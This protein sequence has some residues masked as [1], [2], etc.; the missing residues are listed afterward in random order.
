MQ[1]K[2]DFLKE[3]MSDPALVSSPM[4]LD[5]FNKTY[6]L[7]CANRGCSRAGSNNMGFDRRVQNWQNDLFNNVP[8]A[9]DNDPNFVHI[10][11]K[12]F[13]PAGQRIVVPG[14]PK[15]VNVEPTI[16]PTKFVRSE[17][18]P[19]APIVQ[20]V[21]PEVSKEPEKPLA[22]REEAKKPQNQENTNFEQGTVLPGGEPQIPKE[23]IMQ[24]GSSFTFGDE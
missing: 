5:E 13:A 15:F 10:R 3:C 4:Q 23:T 1:N 7:V 20:E 24:P 11:M 6:C 8:R 2:P 22:V 17:P 18:E 14:G 19:E 16:Q 12:N 9:G 21:A